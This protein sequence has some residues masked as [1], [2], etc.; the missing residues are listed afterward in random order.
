MD[1][2]EPKEYEPS[3]ASW[4][5]ELTKY[6][7]MFNKNSGFLSQLK[8]QKNI[9]EQQEKTK[10]GNKKDKIVNKRDKKSHQKKTES[11]IPAWQKLAS[12]LNIF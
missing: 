6:I 10:D 8:Q 2:N 7:Q 11:N 12:V 9:K 5:H 4:S 3:G 1:S